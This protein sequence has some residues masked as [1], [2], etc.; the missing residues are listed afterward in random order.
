MNTKTKITVIAFALCL[1]FVL[2]L[3][4][5]F[6]LQYFK[7]D[8]F[9]QISLKQ[10]YAKVSKVCK[11]G[12]ILD[13]KGR[14]LAASIK[15]ENVF[16]E[17]AAIKNLKDTAIL[18][19]QIIDIPAHEICKIITESKNPG[20]VVIKKDA[21][22]T[23]QQ[24]QQIRKIFA[25]GIDS[26]WQRQY[27]AGNLTSHIVGFVG[28]DHIG[29]EGIE[30]KYDSKLKGQSN[31][32]VFL[33][34]VCRRPISVKNFAG[35]QL[36]GCDLILTVDSSI[37]E[38]AYDA[39]AR[40]LKEYNAE[41]AVAIVLQPA[42]GAVLAMVSLPDFDP[43][44]LSRATKDTIRNRAITDPYEPGSIF[45]PLIAAWAID[46]KVI[47]CNEKI[48]CENGSYSGKG[49]GTIGEYRN[50][51]GKL[52]VAEILKESSNIGMAKI[53]Q[54]M[55]RDKL[56][57]GVKLFGFGQKTGIDLPGEDAGLVWPAE[58]WTG[59]SVA[60]IPFGHEV[61][62]TAIQ[63][64]RAYAILANGGKVVH[65]YIV[66]AIID[67]QGNKVQLQRL[68]PTA[69]Y[70]IS[71]AAA[72]WTIQ[73][74]LAEVVSDGTGKKAAVK[75]ITVF[76]KTG[77]ANIADAKTGYDETSYIASFA[78][79][80]DARDPQLVV[81]VSIRK[82]DKSLK[83]GY[84]GGTVAAPVVKTIIEKTMKY[85]SRTAP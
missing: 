40:Q 64:A 23:D 62:T 60:R 72:D 53:G 78:G 61:M 13:C 8:Y 11:R 67:S 34:D 48:F 10:R 74:A 54:K 49:F 58:K 1:L 7:K 77:T 81:V 31:Q 5:C 12:T 22:L 24:R 65:P 4:R 19:S 35:N 70:I 17:P 79:G 39:L 29:L 2:L 83:K 56:Y 36:D 25:I 80:A 71:P 47:D 28:T 50:G 9:Q 59:Y 38:F 43:T 27:P 45:K 3:V 42:T 44:D 73:K 21:Q 30:L 66:D 55:G 32:S 41:S 85:H 76:G 57:E 51:F 68:K 20:Y 14:T 26:H 15:S 84:T 33:A 6:Y 37:Q 75:D 82:P 16:A 46:G 18:L 52:T 69:G 63:I